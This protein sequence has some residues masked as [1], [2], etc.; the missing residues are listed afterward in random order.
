VEADRSK[1]AVGDGRLPHQ[2]FFL[3]LTLQLGI[4]LSLLCA[5]A[6]NVGFLLKHRGACAAPDVSLRH[7]IASAVGLFRSKWFTIGM[8][9][10]LVAW[11]F[12]VLALAMAPL[13]LVQAIIAGGLVFLTVLAERWFGFTVGARQWAGVGL[14]ALGLVLL[15]VTLPQHGGAHASYSLAGMIAFE[16]ALLVLGTFLVLSRK[17]G[18]HEHHGVMLGTAA[19]ILFGVSDVAI[20]ALTGAVGDGIGGLLSPWLLTCIIASV[21]AFYASARG[22]QKGEA[23]PVITLTSAAANVTAI[24]GGILVFGDPMP[25]DPVGIVLQSFA[26][27]LVIV[28]AALT[29][30]PLRAARATS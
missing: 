3:L 24:S 27:V 16:S 14:T 12:H 28:A 9:V 17:L 26:F 8:L 15:A 29:P 19:G 21:I 23:V 6:T 5:L 13:S 1:Y 30:A 25:S 4:L 2:T 7:P 10:A 20:K 18:S 22:L 11:T